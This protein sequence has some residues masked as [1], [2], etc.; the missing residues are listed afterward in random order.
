MRALTAAEP[1]NAEVQKLLAKDLEASPESGML[2]TKGWLGCNL[3]DRICKRDFP[4]LG[5][6]VCYPF[7]RVLDLVDLITVE[8]GPCL[9]VGANASVTEIIG[10]GAQVSLGE[11]AF[12]LNRRH[13][14]MRATIDEFI[15]VPFLASRYLLE[16]RGYT[17]GAYSVDTGILG[18]KRPSLPIYQTARDYWAAGAHVEVI[19]WS[20]NVEVHP[21]EAWDFL[22]GLIFFDPLHDDLGVTRG[23]HIK[24]HEKDAIKNLLREARRK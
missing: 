9:G 17:G 1:Q 18:L 23:I 6:I 15:N 11:T 22:A 14:T 8:T 3:S 5:S 19:I 7:N 12:G 21:V 16:A 13:L 2:L 20:L 10:V 24:E 4:V